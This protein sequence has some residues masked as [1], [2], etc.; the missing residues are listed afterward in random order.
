MKYLMC[1]ILAYAFVF[2]AAVFSETSHV[3]PKCDFK[4]ELQKRLPQRMYD[5]IAN[6]DSLKAFKFE[7]KDSLISLNNDQIIELKKILLSDQTYL[8]DVTKEAVFLPDVIF[9]FNVNEESVLLTLSFHAEQMACQYDEQ[10]I[11]LDCDS[12]IGEFKRFSER[13]FG[14]Q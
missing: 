4:S 8:L 10:R 2:E 5:I 7:T 11:V 6:P 12:S 9:I 3:P 14:V 1:V 13:L